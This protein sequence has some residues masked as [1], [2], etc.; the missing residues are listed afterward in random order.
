[1]EKEDI[2]SAFWFGV[3][4]C[5]VI[6]CIVI[7]SYNIKRNNTKTINVKQHNIEYNDGFNTI[8]KELLS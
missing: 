2:V 6:G 3:V 8:P 1:M 4:L 5:F 7:K